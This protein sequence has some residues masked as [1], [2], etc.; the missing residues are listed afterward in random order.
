MNLQHAQDE[1]VEVDWYEMIKLIS[2]YPDI[3]K[4][5]IELVKTSCYISLGEDTELLCNDQFIEKLGLS[6][7][8]KII[9]D[10]VNFLQNTSK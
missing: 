6:N 7:M 5:V 1:E 8:D 9:K 2:K 4:E 10:I 3:C